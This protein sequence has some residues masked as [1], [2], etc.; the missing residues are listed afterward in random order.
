VPLMTN[1]G[2]VLLHIID[3]PNAPA[4][5][6][7]RCWLA[8]SS[9]PRHPVRWQMHPHNATF[10]PTLPLRQGQ[11]SYAADLLGG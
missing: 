4:E 9:P 7:G 8:Q 6:R 11:S 3:K 5:A 2:G 10:L 1:T